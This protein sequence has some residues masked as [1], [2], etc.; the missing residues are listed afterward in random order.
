MGIDNMKLVAE[1][2]HLHISTGIIE[3]EHPVREYDI[4]VINDREDSPIGAVK[5]SIW[6]GERDLDHWRVEPEIILRQDMDDDELYQEH[7]SITRVIPGNAMA[8]QNE[9]SMKSHPSPAISFA[10]NHLPDCNGNCIRAFDVD[11]PSLSE[12]YQ[13][14]LYWKNFDMVG[15]KLAHT[16]N[17]VF[18]QM[19]KLKKDGRNEMTE[20]EVATLLKVAEVGPSKRKL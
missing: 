5:F 13:D 15:S 16:T 7:P 6:R 1:N 19:R 12:T 4:V 2:N 18:S 14:V 20:A 8:F 9:L 17:A 11:D 3:D 10:L